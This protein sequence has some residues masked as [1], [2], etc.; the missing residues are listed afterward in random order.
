MI[1]NIIVPTFKF[2]SNLLTSP[3]S[4]SFLLHG[5]IGSG[6][7]SFFDGSPPALSNHLA[8]QGQTNGPPIFHVEITRDINEGSSNPPSQKIQEKQKSVLRLPQKKVS[9]PLSRLPS[10]TK[11]AKKNN[12]SSV[13]LEPSPLNQHPKYP[14][15]ARSEGREGLVLIECRVTVQG[16]VQDARIKKQSQKTDPDF[17]QQALEAVRTWRYKPIPHSV[18]AILPIRFHLQD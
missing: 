13:V 7:S 16:E 10:Q 11:G 14:E 3:A 12:F 4:L 5:V 17:E 18:C 8:Y 2:L 1:R 15:N 6:L 9:P